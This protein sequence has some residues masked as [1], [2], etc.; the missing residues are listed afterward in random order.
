MGKFEILKAIVDFA[1]SCDANGVDLFYSYSPHVDMVTIM[2]Y[3]GGKWTPDNVIELS[4]PIYFD[5]P[6]PLKE[7]EK[8]IETVIDKYYPI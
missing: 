1:E 5:E 8:I 4:V 3:S 7:L 2:V 6:E